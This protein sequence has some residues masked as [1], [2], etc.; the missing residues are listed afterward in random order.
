MPAS[1]QQIRNLWILLQAAGAVRRFIKVQI[2]ATD[3]SV[4]LALGDPHRNV[5]IAE[6]TATIPAGENSVDVDYTKHIT[7]TYENF[8][9]SHVGLKSS[10]RVIERFGNRYNPSRLDIPASA[11]HDS[12]IQTVYPARLDIF[13]PK[14]PRPQDI[15]LPRAFEYRTRAGEDVETVFGA[16]PFHVEIWQMAAG[17]TEAVATPT[18]VG[19][20]SIKAGERQ[21]VFAF[22]QDEVDRK[23]GW[24][25][26]G[27]RILRPA[28]PRST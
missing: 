17:S 15:V 24:L 5:R 1:G 25:P 3:G 23:R 21:L 28:A 18:V 27:T 13:P 19:A 22:V 14:S 20:C 16:D 7:R 26:G 4:Y 8:D 9:G 2:S 12:L 11:E 10:G 6:V